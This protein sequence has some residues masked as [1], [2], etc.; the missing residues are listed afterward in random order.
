MTLFT[1]SNQPSKI[2]ILPLKQ[3]D[4]PDISTYW[5]ATQSMIANRNIPKHLLLSRHHSFIYSM[6]DACSLGPP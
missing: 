5:F 3:E 1:E 6:K 2:K 4:M